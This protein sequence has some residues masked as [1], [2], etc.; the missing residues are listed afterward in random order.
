MRRKGN[1][2][3]PGSAHGP[4]GSQGPLDILY[5][6]PHCWFRFGTFSYERVQAHRGVPAPK[7]QISGFPRS[8]GIQGCMGP[9]R[10]GGP[11]PHSWSFG[12]PHDSRFG[13]GL[14]VNS[15]PTHGAC[16]KTA[17]SSHFSGG[18]SGHPAG[19]ARPRICPG[20]GWGCVW[21]S[22]GSQGPRGSAG[23]G[24]APR[25]GGW[26]RPTGMGVCRVAARAAK[27]RAGRRPRRPGRAAG[28]QGGAAAAG[29]WW[30]FGPCAC[31]DCACPPPF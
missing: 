25:P 27:K 15:D 18:A 21:A 17:A 5:G 7:G 28:A 4:R 22:S 2:H 13:R 3:Q 31:Q 19:C 9:E 1:R 12:R 23:A 24:G 10:R 6:H 26:N 16:A 14:Q 20:R 8:E 29:G 11:G 30:G